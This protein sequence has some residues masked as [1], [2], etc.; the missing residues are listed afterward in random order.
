[1]RIAQA[2]DD[3][4]LRLFHDGQRRGLPCRLNQG[5]GLARGPLIA[6]MDADDVAFPERLARQVAFMQ[7]H[8]TVDLLASSALLIGADQK[9]V[10]TLQGGYRHQEI[11]RQPWGRFPMVHP[12]WMGRVEWF[13]RHPY[14]EWANQCEDQALLYQSFS[15]STFMGLPDVLLAYSY[16][17]LSA[18][19]TA[20]GRWN[21]LRT[22]AGSRKLTH[23]CAGLFWHGF[24]LLRD[25]IAMIVGHDATV[26]RQRTIPASS[27]VIR[28]WNALR[29]RISMG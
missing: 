10:G 11:C 19:K 14:P 25:M 6:R 29:H 20:V 5:V 8:P 2:T 16:A 12:T 18:S 3:V 23:L 22:L 1:M 17:K 4:R 9:P 15:G 27:E 24:C 21:F 26:I 7:T 13:R 28:T